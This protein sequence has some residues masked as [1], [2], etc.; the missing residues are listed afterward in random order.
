MGKMRYKSLFQ[1]EFTSNFCYRCGRYGATDW[2]H[3]FNT[4]NKKRSEKYGAMVKLCRNCH[5]WVHLYE[6]NKYKQIAEQK[7]LT[8]Y[9]MTERDF[10][11]I[12]G[13]NYL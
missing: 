5:E 2:H 1:N 12:F 3:I 9:D 10:I 8:Y 7:I 6:M 13:K 4:S 11:D